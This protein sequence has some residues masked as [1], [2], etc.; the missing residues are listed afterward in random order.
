MKEFLKIFKRS[1]RISSK[2]LFKNLQKI[3]GILLSKIFRRFKKKIFLNFLIISF[4]NHHY[5]FGIKNLLE[6]FWRNFWRSS[7]EL[8]IFVIIF[9][10]KISFS[11]WT[12]I[13]RNKENILLESQTRPFSELIYHEIT[14][15]FS[16]MKWPKKRV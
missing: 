13:L 1:S 9:L 15:C 4:E 2:F 3:I 5:I 6:I 16:N 12:I 8:K 11:L 7:D 10:R 14:Q